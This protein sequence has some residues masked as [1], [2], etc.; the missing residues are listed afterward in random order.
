[1]KEFIVEHRTKVGAVAYVLRGT[2]IAFGSCDTL[3][4]D[5]VRIGPD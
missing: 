5:A 1:M 4:C 2:P 3:V